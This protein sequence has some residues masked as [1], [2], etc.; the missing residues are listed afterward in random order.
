[1]GFNSPRPRMGA[2]TQLR[3]NSTCLRQLVHFYSGELVPRFL[4]VNGNET[5]QGASSLVIQ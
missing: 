5:R 2:I 3:R 4:T 1:V